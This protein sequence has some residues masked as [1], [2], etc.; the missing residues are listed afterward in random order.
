M[1]L[2][3]VCAGVAAYFVA[4]PGSSQAP[5]AGK[6]PSRA[7]A[8][9]V[10]NES[11]AETLPLVQALEQKLVEGSLV[12]NG[13]EK[14]RISLSN[15]SDKNLAVTISAGDTFSAGNSTL[16]VL[17]DRRINA[18]PGSTVS[19]TVA[20]AAVSSTATVGEARYFVAN[21]TFPRVTPLLRYLKEHPEISVEAAQTA[22]LALTENLPVRAFAKFPSAVGE[23]AYPF[24]TTPFRVEI[25][26]IISA[27]GVLRAIGVPDIELA[28]T[29]DPQLKIEAMIDPLAHAAAMRYYGIASTQEWDYWRNELTNG[30]IRTR[31]YALYGIARF[32]PEIALQ[33]LPDWAREQRTNAV[34]RQS[35][36]LALAETQR[37]GAQ[38]ILAQLCHELGTETELGYAAREALK[39]LNA[40]LDR[41]GSRVLAV[42]FRTSRDVPEL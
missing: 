28:L 39:A 38:P 14:L 34:F 15:R 18:A 19:A 29:I 3:V 32:F 37:P 16:V 40:R 25:R 13:R 36:I 6:F 27:L 35:A 9:A 26:E 7:K 11:P 4:Q 20:T 31:H 33:M 1:A 12:G 10:E 21:T 42:A 22:V 5:G 23:D 2:G 8:G 17:R 24:D 41:D 30:D